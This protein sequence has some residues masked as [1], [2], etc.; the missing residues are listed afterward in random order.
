MLQIDI[1]SHLKSNSDTDSIYIWQI[2]LSVRNSLYPFLK[3]Q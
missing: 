3:K 1:I 2:N